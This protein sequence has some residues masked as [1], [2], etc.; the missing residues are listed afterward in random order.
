MGSYKFLAYLECIRSYAWSFDHSDPDLSSVLDMAH[1]QFDP[2]TTL[3]PPHFGPKHTSAQGTFWPEECFSPNNTSVQCLPR[4][5]N[6]SSQYTSPRGPN[7]QLPI[8]CFCCMLHNSRLENVPP[9]KIN[10]EI[11]SSWI[12]ERTFKLTYILTFW[13]LK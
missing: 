10:N 12:F 2:K 1:S 13:K 5:G 8:C 7:F 3:A 9:L 11:G 4:P 6:T